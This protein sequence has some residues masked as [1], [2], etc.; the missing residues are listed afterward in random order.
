MPIV[1]PQR[2][3]KVVRIQTRNSVNN[4]CWLLLLFTFIIVL[5]LAN[6]LL[7]SKA[8]PTLVHLGD[9]LYSIIS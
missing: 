9:S 3:R 4:K 1:I 2:K 8:Y 6:S 5:P 7:N